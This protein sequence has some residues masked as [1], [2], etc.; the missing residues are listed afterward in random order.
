M[1]YD[2]RKDAHDSYYAAIEAKRLRLTA[3]LV[4]LAEHGIEPDVQELLVSG[5]PMRGIRPGA[6][7]A[8]LRAATAG[9]A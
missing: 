5:N 8:A 1:S 4:A 6:L 2:P 9:V 3:A 7:E